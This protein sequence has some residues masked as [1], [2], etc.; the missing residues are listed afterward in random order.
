MQ[1]RSAAAFSSTG[2]GECPPRTAAGACP[3]ASTAANRPTR[4][5]E[6]WA[7]ADADESSGESTAVSSDPQAQQ[8]PQAAAAPPLVHW[9]AASDPA[10][11]RHAPGILAAVQLATAISLW[12]QPPLQPPQQPVQLPLLQP[13]PQPQQPALA[14][15]EPDGESASTVCLP[16]APAEADD[17]PA[18]APPP[19]HRKKRQA[20]ADHTQQW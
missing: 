18:T 16:Q 2:E 19:P 11:Q 13:Q 3:H 17:A 12:L 20:D 7:D 15:A 6:C 10:T 4:S 14:A 9:L 1:Q 8:R 5:S